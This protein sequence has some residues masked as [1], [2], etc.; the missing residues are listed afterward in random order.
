MQIHPIREYISKEVKKRDQQIPEVAPSTVYQNREE[1]YDTILKMTDKE[2][3]GK[4]VTRSALWKIK[5]KI[6]DRM[7][8][9]LNSNTVKIVVQ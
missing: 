7:R 5:K 9:N 4:G 8:L 1:I 3:E 6:K 2:A